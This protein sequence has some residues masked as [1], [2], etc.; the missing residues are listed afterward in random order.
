MGDVVRR[1]GGSSKHFLLHHAP[2]RENERKFIYDC[3]SA[4]RTYKELTPKMWEWYL[5]IIKKY[6]K[7]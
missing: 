3:L 4:Q 6:R 2:L 1:I 7:Q 5:S